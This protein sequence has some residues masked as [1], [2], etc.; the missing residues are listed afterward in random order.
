M[1]VIVCTTGADFF[2]MYVRTLMLLLKS[3]LKA[4]HQ[5]PEQHAN[6]C[7]SE[8]GNNGIK[9]NIISSTTKTTLL[10]FHLKMKL[11]CCI[12]FCMNLSRGDLLTIASR[13]LKVEQVC[14]ACSMQTG[15]KKK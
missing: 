5:K 4:E 3:T 10:F 8:C 7:R 15:H 11:V 12:W 13:V 1:V 6:N 2:L 9:I 14:A